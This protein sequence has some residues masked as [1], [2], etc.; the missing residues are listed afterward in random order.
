MMKEGDRNMAVAGIDMG[1]LFTKVVILDGEKIL[2]AVTLDIGDDWM[3][4]AVQASNEAL[5]QAGL[6]REDVKYVIATGAGNKKVRAAL[7]ERL[8]EERSIAMCTAKGAVYLFPHARA[9][10]DS[11][12]D[13]ITA[14]KLGADGSLEASAGYAKCASYTGLFLD[15]LGA[16]LGVPVNEMGAEAQKATDPPELTS[17]CAVFAVAEIISLVHRD[18]AIP[19][20]DILAS[21]HEAMANGLYGVSQRVRMRSDVVMCGGVARN[22]DVVKRIEAKLGATMLK[23]ENPQI[24]GALGAALLAQQELARQAH[25][26]PTPLS[27]GGARC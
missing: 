27:G 12:A 18:P 7:K 3:S 5:K 26:S 22:F 10:L 16:M 14:M 9:V 20:P 15:Y 1:A 6:K 24:L 2:A 23:P 8:I 4:E 19:V 25:V 17:R 21:V 11:G 13:S